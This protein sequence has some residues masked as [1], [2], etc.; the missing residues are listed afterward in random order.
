MFLN[1]PLEDVAL[2]SVALKTWMMVSES[3]GCE[4]KK[5]GF[6][7]GL[8]CLL[9]AQKEVVGVNEGLSELARGS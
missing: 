7:C 8:V 6:R 1:N 4:T 9:E 2:F 5:P 3:H